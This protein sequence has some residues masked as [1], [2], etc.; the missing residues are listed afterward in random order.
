MDFKNMAEDMEKLESN[1][2]TSKQK[3]KDLE[4]QLALRKNQQNTFNLLKAHFK[5][6]ITFMIDIIDH[7]CIR[8]CENADFDKDDYNSIFILRKAIENKLD[9]IST[10]V[11]LDF[12]KEL[13]KIRLWNSQF[14]HK[15]QD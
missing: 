14:R 4:L 13:N 9:L 6:Y 8:S 10:E 11:E 3:I 5:N 1:E 12:S 2:L 15:K 7:I